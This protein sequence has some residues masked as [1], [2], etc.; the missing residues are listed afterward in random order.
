MES[1]LIREGSLHPAS[2]L[3]MELGT[4]FSLSDPQFSDLQ[5]GTPSWSKGF[6]FVLS[7]RLQGFPPR[8][9]PGSLDHLSV[10]QRRA[11]GKKEFQM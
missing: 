11:E 4:Q 1:T 3:W 6:Q 7:L 2:S 10:E 5:S 9:G 8:K